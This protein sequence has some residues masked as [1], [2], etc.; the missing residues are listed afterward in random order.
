MLELSLE[1]AGEKKKLFFFLILKHLIFF[2]A[3]VTFK[4][5]KNQRSNDFLVENMAKTIVHAF[6][7]CR[8]QKCI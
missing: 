5:I 3:E 4:A 6:G 1:S 8:D 2:G 7:L